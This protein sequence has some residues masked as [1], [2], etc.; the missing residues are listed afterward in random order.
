MAAR[1]KRAPGA[2]RKPKG[3]FAGKSATIT[4]RIRPDTREALEKVARAN[5]RSLSQEVEFRLRAGLLSTDAQRRNQAL[6]HSIARMAEAIEKGTGQSW[7]ED[8][9]TSLALRSAIEA[10]IFHFAPISTDA[11]AA[12]PSK[13][14]EEAAKMFPHSPKNF[15]RPPASVI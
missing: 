7:L 2:G 6:T 10:F 1:R 3:E 9:F 12:V 11:T 13:I 15:A 4:T 5:R 8:F 14:E